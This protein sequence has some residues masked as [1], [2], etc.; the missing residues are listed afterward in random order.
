MPEGFIAKEFFTPTAEQKKNYFITGRDVCLELPDEQFGRFSYSLEE[1]KEILNISPPIIYKVFGDDNCWVT[2]WKT[3]SNKEYTN[4]KVAILMDS[5]VY[6][7]LSK[8]AW[9]IVYH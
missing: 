1:W 2:N 4:Y 7:A 6:K 5:E 9:E 8:K 3:C